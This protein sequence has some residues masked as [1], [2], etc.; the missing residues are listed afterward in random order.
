MIWIRITK[1][2]ETTTSMPCLSTTSSPL[3]GL[4]DRS[5][6]CAAQCSAVQRSPVPLPIPPIPSSSLWKRKKRNSNLSFVPHFGLS[7]SPKDLQMSRSHCGEACDCS[8]VQPVI[9]V[10]RPIPIQYTAHLIPSQIPTVGRFTNRGSE[11]RGAWGP[12]SD[13]LIL[14]GQRCEMRLTNEPLALGP[15]CLCI[16]ICISGIRDVDL[17]ASLLHMIWGD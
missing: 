17:D 10:G 16:R 5:V 11:K 4:V 15:A 12:C 9:R 2:D 7:G 3:R 6:L 8:T 14:S 13:D 1:A